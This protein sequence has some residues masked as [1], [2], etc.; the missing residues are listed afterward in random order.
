MP[1]L[2]FSFKLIEVQI[3]RF[4]IKLKMFY[5]VFKIYRRKLQKIQYIFFFINLLVYFSNSIL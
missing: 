4:K 5:F 3:Y 2:Y 1:I